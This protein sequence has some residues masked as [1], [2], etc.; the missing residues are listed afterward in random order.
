[1]EIRE[2]K[3]LVPFPVGEL[4]C[5]AARIDGHACSGVDAFS[6]I[7]SQREWIREAA[8]ARGHESKP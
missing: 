7:R 2:D 6:A 4:R 3:E 8:C 5:G 1:M